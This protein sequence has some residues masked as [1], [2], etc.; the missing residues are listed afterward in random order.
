VV[1]QQGGSPAGAFHHPV[2]NLCD[3]Q[4][5]PDRVGDPRELADT[6]YGPDELAEIVQGGHGYAFVPT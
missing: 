2:R 4:A 3:L 1:E 5:S 6:V